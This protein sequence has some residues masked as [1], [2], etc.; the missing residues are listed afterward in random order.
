MLTLAELLG[1]PSEMWK[2]LYHWTNAFVGED[3]PEFRQSPEAM[4]QVMGE[5]FA[6]AQD[7]QPRVARQASISTV[8]RHTVQ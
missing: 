2:D 6:F 8:N 3:D 5:F 1:A 4:A 7:D